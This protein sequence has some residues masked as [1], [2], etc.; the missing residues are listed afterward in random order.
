MHIGK[1][2]WT[3]LKFTEIPTSPQSHYIPT[4]NSPVQ[5]IKKLRIIQL[6]VNQE[7]RQNEYALSDMWHPV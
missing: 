1:I 5:V 4:N 3:E 6:R 2:N 7:R